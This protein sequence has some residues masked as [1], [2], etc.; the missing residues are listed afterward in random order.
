MSAD[1]TRARLGRGV[2]WL[3]LGLSALWAVVII[4][5]DAQAWPLTIWIAAT[6]GPI[7]YLQ[8]SESRDS[9]TEGTRQ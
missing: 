9:N 4:V 1:E 6:L 2:P 5:T 8:R 3:W 7:T